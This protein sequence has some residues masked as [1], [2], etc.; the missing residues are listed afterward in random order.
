MGAIQPQGPA[1]LQGWIPNN[2]YE[3]EYQGRL[4]TGLPALASQYS[5]VAMRAVVKV[6]AKT[7]DILVLQ[8]QAPK[9]IDVNQV[10]SPKQEG[11]NIPYK[12]GGWNW[13]NLNLPAFKEVSL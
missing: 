6:F 10:L 9:Y 12:T 13:R 2:V 1:T 4:L 8:V 7:A 3:F 5:G 11:A